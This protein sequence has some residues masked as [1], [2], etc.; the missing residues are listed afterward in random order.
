M[1]K[2][3]YLHKP[4]SKKHKRKISNFHK[5]LKHTEETKLKI[6]IALK[7]IPK[8]KEHN[9]KVSETLK[10][11]GIKPPDH[12]GS[13]H[14]NWQGGISYKPY[15]VNWTKT[16][17]KSIRERDK[18]ICQ[19]CGKESAICVHHIDYNKKNCNPDNLITLCYSCHPKTN[20]N[21]NYWIKFFDNLLKK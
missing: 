15:S 12:K 13:N 2:G 19:I 8:T 17:R 11:K 10:R 5:G 20:Y 7:G 16:L 14:P 3:F 9:K 18:Y 21:K 1:P 6:G 4:L